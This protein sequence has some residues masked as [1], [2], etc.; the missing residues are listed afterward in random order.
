MEVFLELL[1][2]T[3]P[4]LVVL[5]TA[6]FLLKLYLESQF[7]LQA[8]AQRGESLKTTLQLRLQAYERLTLFCERAAIHNA[9]LRARMPGMRVADLRNALLASVNQ[10]FDHNAVQQLY[11]SETLWK[12]ISLAKEETLALIA[13]T[14]AGLDADA[15][16]DLLVDALFGHFNRLDAPTPLQRAISAIR[17]EAKELF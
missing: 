10:E 5:A 2:Y 17:T 14:A 12:I 1:K 16:A 8:T 6:Y 7:R 9:L 11:V 13:R 4:A 3:I 15:D